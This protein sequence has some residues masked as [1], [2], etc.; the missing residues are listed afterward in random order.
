[1]PCKRGP[2]EIPSSFHYVRTQPVDLAMNQ[3]EGPNQDV[4]MLAP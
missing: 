1:M 3:D 4:T 2:R